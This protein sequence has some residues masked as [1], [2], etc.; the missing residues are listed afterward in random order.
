[1]PSESAYRDFQSL[2]VC[3]A[4]LCIFSGGGLIFGMPA[5]FPS[6]Y[7][8]G[9]WARLCTSELDATTRRLSHYVTLNETTCADDI[10]HGDAEKCC[11]SQLLRVGLTSSATFF[12]ADAA[13]GP[14][15]EY[16]DRAGPYRCL[17]LIHI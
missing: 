1:M 11:E 8:V 17:S 13:A 4:C 5:L 9:F 14:W 15:G 12:M 3:V 7:G 10:G 2:A 16:V 6:L